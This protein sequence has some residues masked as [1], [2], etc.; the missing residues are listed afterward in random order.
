MTF[1][2]LDELTALSATAAVTAMR[3]GEITAEAYAT[4][5]LDR[6]DRLRH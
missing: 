2:P 1:T 5:L 3:N 6:A 4:A